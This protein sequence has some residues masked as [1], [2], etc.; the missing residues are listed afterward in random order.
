MDKF[1][2]FTKSMD[3]PCDVHFTIT[4]SVNLLA[5]IPRCVYVGEV[6]TLVVEDSQGTVV[7]YENVQGVL[8]IR[9]HKVLPTSTAN[10]I[11]GML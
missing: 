1:A 2:N 3:S 8:P 9:P 10:G 11:I 5:S 7:I 6:G 4:P